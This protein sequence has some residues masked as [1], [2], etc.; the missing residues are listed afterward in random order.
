MLQTVTLSG[1][2]VRLEPL[3]VHHADALAQ[4][5]GD[6]ESWRYHGVGD[7]TER[8]ALDAFIASVQDEPAQ[9][10]GLNFA[11]VP[12]ATGR[13]VG[14]TAL[15]DV[16]LPHRRGEIGRTWLA[17]ETRRTGINTE[18][19]YLILGHAFETLGL[20]RVQLKTDTQNVVSRR[21]IERLGAKEEGT[22][23][24][25]M[26]LHN[27]N[28]RDTVYYSILTDE[29]MGGVKAHLQALLRPYA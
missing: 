24:A 22:L 11:I 12:V 20:L 4:T 29:W 21:A 10:V 16:S 26:I 25:H 17:P 1:A 28:R 18:A 15:W 8:A 7:L 2:L 6:P 27:G 3:S 9:G 23:R 5:T 19:K 13:A 14:A